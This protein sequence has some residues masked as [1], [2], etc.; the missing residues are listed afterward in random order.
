ST[1]ASASLFDNQ[2]I[3]PPRP[4]NKPTPRRNGRNSVTGG[5]GDAFAGGSA[6]NN[7]TR[8]NSPA[9][10][11]NDERTRKSRRFM[12]LTDTTKPRLRNAALAYDRPRSSSAP[13]F[14]LEIPLSP[15]H[16]HRQCLT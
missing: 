5:S 13:I 4:V 1:I 10:T 15:A 2:P 11:S 3:D 16:S 9:D 8:G 7:D 6:E 14:R 12:P